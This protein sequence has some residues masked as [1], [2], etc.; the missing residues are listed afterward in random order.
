MALFTRMGT[1]VERLISQDTD[2]CGGVWITCK[3]KG[4]DGNRDIHL[5][6]LRSD[7]GARE[8]HDVIADLPVVEVAGLIHK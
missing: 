1:P 8:V 6:D 4:M 7:G 3:L 5:S 2:Q